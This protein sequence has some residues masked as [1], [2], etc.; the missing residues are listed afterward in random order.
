MDRRC[1]DGRAAARRARGARRAAHR[2]RAALGR[3]GVPRDAAGR[4][5]HRAAV[6]ARP[7]RLGRRAAASRRRLRGRF[8][9]AYVLPNSIKSAL[10]PWLARIPMRIGYRGEG[11]VAAAQSAPAEPGGP[12]ADGRVLQRARRTA[13]PSTSAR[14]QLTSRRRGAI[15]A[16]LS[17]PGSSAAAYWAFAPGAEYGPAKRWP[18]DALRR[19]RAF[20]AALER[21]AGRAARLGQRGRAVRRDRRRRARRPA[22][23]SPAR[24]RWSTRWR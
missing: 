19:A 5:D 2:R 10:M 1:G 18:A 4:R 20:A 8:D 24:H 3:A 14:P 7:A 22:A 6:R 21:A 16:A 15:D 9:A 12:A 23:S 11:R 13:C 17:A